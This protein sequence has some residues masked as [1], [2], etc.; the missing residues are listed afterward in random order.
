MGSNR[1]TVVEH[2]GRKQTW[3]EI[4]ISAT[5]ETQR[6]SKLILLKMDKPVTSYSA[7]GV[8]MFH[9]FDCGKC[10]GRGLAWV[11]GGV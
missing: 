6:D 8:G 4:A 1:V 2:A 9:Y 5:S 7:C 11:G 3:T 10:W